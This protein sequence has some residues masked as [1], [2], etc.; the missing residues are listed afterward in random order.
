MLYDL[1]RLEKR[2]AARARI[3]P[4]MREVKCGASQATKVRHGMLPPACSTW[5]GTRTSE[6]AFH[7]EHTSIA[8]G[9]RD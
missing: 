5:D 1:R 2:L 8:V 4:A 6:A 9:N 7:V 3:R